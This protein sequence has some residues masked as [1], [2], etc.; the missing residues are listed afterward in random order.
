M[1]HEEQHGTALNGV[2][3]LFGRAAL[4]VVLHHVLL[5]LHCGAHL[6]R[7]SGVSGGGDVA[8]GGLESARSS[9]SLRF[10]NRLMLN[11]AM[12]RPRSCRRCGT[13]R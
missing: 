3:A 8:R 6:A 5:L 12:E 7:V 4:P 11:A 2:R 9:T 13:V 1:Q 10:R